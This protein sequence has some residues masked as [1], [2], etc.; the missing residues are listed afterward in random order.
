MELRY[1]ESY[2]RN[3]AIFLDYT[4]IVSTD[5]LIPF[6][7]LNLIHISETLTISASEMRCKNLKNLSIL[8]RN[9]PG[10]GQHDFC[11][12]TYESKGHDIN[13]YAIEF[14]LMNI[15]LRPNYC[16]LFGFRFSLT[17]SG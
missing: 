14:A 2:R 15:N 10:A 11:L 4:E 8:D 13:I 12:S 3:G 9:T 5:G 7:M 17:G 16:V 1:I 6:L